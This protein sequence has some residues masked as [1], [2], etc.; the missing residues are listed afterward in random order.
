MN[1]NALFL[2]ASMLETMWNTRKKDMIDLI[3]PFIQYAVATTHSQGEKIDV[4]RVRNYVRKNFGYDDLPNSI[5]ERVFSREGNIKKISGEYI[6]ESLYDK[7][8][9]VFEQRRQKCDDSLQR[10]G[11]NI[12]QFLSEHMKKRRK[13][14]VDI[15]INDL[16]GFFSRYGI[17]VG[18]ERLEEK[19]TEIS[20]SEQDYYIAQFIYE[21]KDNKRPEYTDI[22]ELVK[23]YFLKSALYLQGLNGDIVKGSFS[24]VTFYYDTPFLLRLLEFKTEEDFEDAKE[25]HNVLTERNGRFHFFPQT[26]N[27]INNILK[28][29]SKN[30]GRF[31]THTLE[32]LDRKNYTSSDVNRLFYSWE[33]RLEKQYNVT[34]KEMPTYNTDSS[35]SIDWRY[36]IDEK[37]LKDYLSKSIKYNTEEAMMAD[38]NSVLAIHRIRKDV[39][40]K[41]IEHCKALFVTTN[42][43][44]ARYVNK[45]YKKNVNEDTFPL[46]I[47]DSDMSALAWIK[48]AS[49]NS[50]IPEAHLLK[51]AYMAMQPTPELLDKLEEVM[52]RMR[53]EGELT[54][55]MALAIR[56]S[57]FIKKDVLLASFRGIKSINEDVVK[58][59]KEKIKREFSE[60]AREDERNKSKEKERDNYFKLLANADEEARKEARRKANTVKQRIKI[61]AVIVEVALIIVA[62]IG[63]VNSFSVNSGMQ[64]VLCFVLLVFNCFSVY[65]TIRAREKLISR[66]IVRICN[67]VYDKEYNKKQKEYNA[68]IKQDSYR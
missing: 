37:G 36:V 8:V 67:N 11:E 61:G 43:P 25:L 41:Q 23:G 1:D 13:Y 10:L 32:G 16:M 34:V 30:I 47:T 45:Y 3:A 12:S 42:V 50:K 5:I 31:S 35:G 15:A 68:I 60:K 64:G 58:S 40:S 59:A 21:A 62:I 57:E 44:L 63:L 46:L 66:F 55:E 14:T 27:E 20:N 65:D 2:G 17:N 54:E 38:L 29:Y 48:C 33:N 56:E 24:K 28:A 51:N 18:L 7:E 9:A 19:S 26:E 49:T 6:Y 39:T 53:G 4:R 22:I 52:N